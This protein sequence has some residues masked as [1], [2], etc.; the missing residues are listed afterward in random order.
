[1]TAPWRRTKRLLTS[2]SP[3][4][5]AVFFIPAAFLLIFLVIFPALQTLYISFL[6]P[7]GDFAGLENYAD[8]LGRR[9]TIDVADGQIPLGT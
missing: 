5:R 9:E 3:Y 7:T 1:M 6:R 8:V 4:V 2:F